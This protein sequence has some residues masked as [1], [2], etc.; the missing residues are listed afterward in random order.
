MKAQDSD[1]TGYLWQE[2]TQDAHRW[3]V[4]PQVSDSYSKANGEKDIQVISSI[5]LLVRAATGTA[6][7]GRK[8][9]YREDFRL[10]TIFAEG[11]GRNTC[12]RVTA[13]CQ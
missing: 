6:Y 9:R 2:V 1:L 11:V 5:N 10:R 12:Q 3:V 4:E 8:R 7:A 13:D